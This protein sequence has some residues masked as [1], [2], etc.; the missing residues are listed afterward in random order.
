MAKN[1]F[2]LAE[3]IQQTWRGNINRR[4]FFKTLYVYLTPTWDRAL[5]FINYTLFY[6]NNYL[7]TQTSDFGC[8][9]VE[10]CVFF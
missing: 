10:F 6:K 7:R 5:L 8:P 9:H 3:R 2:F 1:T 4:D